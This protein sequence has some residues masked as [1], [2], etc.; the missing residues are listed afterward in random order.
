MSAKH[1]LKGLKIPLR[2]IAP[3]RKCLPPFKTKLRCLRTKASRSSLHV[4][5]SSSQEA[6]RVPSRLLHQR[7]APALPL[8]HQKIDLTTTPTTC[9]WYESS[10]PRSVQYMS[11]HVQNVPEAKLIN[12]H[13]HIIMCRG[14]R[15]ACLCPTHLDPD[16]KGPEMSLLFRC[17]QL[18]AK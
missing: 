6:P 16:T 4:A 5:S 2:L 11:E 17:W 15:R 7:S 3:Q 14:C 1:T 13:I 12:T 18:K 9:V 8:C 10:T